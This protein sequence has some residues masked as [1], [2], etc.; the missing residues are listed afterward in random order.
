MIERYS[1]REMRALWDPQNKTQR[2]LDV[3]IAVCEA[4]EYYGFIPVG[5]T[6]KIRANAR[7]DLQRIA[8][9]EKITR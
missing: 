2:W 4:Q 5:T 9:L 7:F 8:A 3:E 1:T 6:E